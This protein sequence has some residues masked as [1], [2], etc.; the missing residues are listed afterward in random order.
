MK[1]IVLRVIV[2]FAF[3][4]SIAIIDHFFDGWKKYV[5]IGLVGGVLFPLNDKKYKNK[6]IEQ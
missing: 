6:K 3:V 4:L 5:F 1:L 2:V